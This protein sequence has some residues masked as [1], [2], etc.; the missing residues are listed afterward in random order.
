[1]PIF[2]PGDKISLD[3]AIAGYTIDAAFA[4]F[5]DAETGSI[6]VGKYADLVVLDRDLFAIPAAEISEAK[7]TATLFAG[8]LVYGKLENK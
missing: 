5:L 2:N 4:N 3:A 8:D 1:M 6:E 7:V